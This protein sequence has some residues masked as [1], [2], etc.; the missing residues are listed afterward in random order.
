MPFVLRWTLLLP[1]V[2]GLAACG[3]QSVGDALGLSRRA[4]DEFQVVQRAPLVVPP[5]FGLRP[6]EPGAPR[7]Q[8]GTPS[9]RA[10]IALTGTPTPEGDA[11]PGQAAFLAA[12]GASRADPNIRDVITA[13]G[14]GLAGLDAGR[15]WFILDFQRRAYARSQANPLDATAEAERLREAGINVRGARVDSR[16]VPTGGV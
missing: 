1:L 7:P 11:T 5:E 8:E 3:G 6:P 16:P 4:P 14:E 2:L 12:A 15:F 9:E 10:Q 13:E